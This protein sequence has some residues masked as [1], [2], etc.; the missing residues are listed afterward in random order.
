MNSEN[1]GVAYR[2]DTLIYCAVKKGIQKINL[3]DESIV[4]VTRT[5]VDCFSY[6]A[7]FRDKMFYT[8]STKDTVT[9]IDFQGKLQWMF[10]NKS[11]INVPYDISVDGNG[12]VYVVGEDS[13][14]VV[15]ISPNGHD[16][17]QVLTSENGLEKPVVV[18]VDR[19]NCKMLVANREGKAIVYSLV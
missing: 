18:H 6:V 5:M 4:N 9:C 19:S 17:R 16:Y 15:I 2:E 3:N 1:T 8:Q 10:K 11:I 7:T 14:N 12:N 13:N